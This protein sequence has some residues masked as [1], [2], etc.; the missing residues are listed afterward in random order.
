MI[1][2]NMGL[3]DQTLALRW[4]NNNIR[5][6]GGD[7]KKVTIM[8]NSAGGVSVH[9]HYMSPL[10]AGL[11]QNGYSSSGTALLT[12]AF[13]LDG[14]V[15]MKKFANA[16]NCPHENTRQLLQCLKSK[17]FEQLSTAYG[18]VMVRLKVTVLETW[19]D[20]EFTF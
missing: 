12:S 4:V 13:D 11:F 15:P 2:G 3:K 19:F 18:D 9:L 5:F 1:S 6:F 17:S 7:P 8:G 14:S 16:S 10:S 20:I